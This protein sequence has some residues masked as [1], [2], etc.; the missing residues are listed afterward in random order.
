M[1]A[2]PVSVTTMGDFLEKD[3]LNYL[4][5]CCY[6][7]KQSCYSV[8]LSCLENKQSEKTDFVVLGNCRGE[9]SNLSW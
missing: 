6:R 8:K 9:F 3:N 5:F 4:N 1:T 2:V 7:L